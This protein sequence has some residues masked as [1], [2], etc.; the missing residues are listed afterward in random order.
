MAEGTTTQP[1]KL[2]FDYR[3]AL[4]KTL[5]STEFKI[6]EAITLRINRNHEDDWCFPSYETLMEDTAITGRSTIARGIQ[7]MVDMGVLRVKGELG[8]VTYYQ[9]AQ[10]SQE[11]IDSFRPVQKLNGST[12][13]K[14]ERVEAEPVQKLDSTSPKNVLLPVQKLDSNVSKLTIQ[15]NDKTEAKA[16]AANAAQMS[17]IE[18]FDR[19]YRAAD[20]GEGET[21]KP[22][23][24]R[25]TVIGQAFFHAFARDPNYPRLLKMAK[26]LGSGLELIKLMLNNS[27]YPIGDD[28]H[29]YLQ[30]IISNKKAAPPPKQRGSPPGGIDFSKYGPGGKYAHLVASSG[31]G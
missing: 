10:P 14:I 21:H 5:T 15:N 22:N 1:G 11:L 7:H 6:L 23:V 27:G 28:P 26:D 2:Y 20:R 19:D 29:D 31:E 25:A 24:D 30:K 13:P 8:K 18:I 3:R 4:L 12:S 17:P 16:S 9:P